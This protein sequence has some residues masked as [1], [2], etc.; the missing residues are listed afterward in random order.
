MKVT[1]TTQRDT[2]TGAQQAQTVC[3]GQVRDYRVLTNMDAGYF[4]VHTPEGGQRN[5][6]SH[7]EVLDYICGDA[8]DRYVWSIASTYRTETRTDAD[9]SLWLDYVDE[10]LRSTDTDEQTPEN[11]ID[12]LDAYVAWD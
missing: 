2:R 11:L 8:E 7:D 9:A 5:F 10:W 6:Q 12:Y 3:Y 4:S 1:I